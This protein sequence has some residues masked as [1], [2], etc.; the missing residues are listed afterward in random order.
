LIYRL[1]HRRLADYE[2]RIQDAFDHCIF[3]SQREL[4]VFKQMPSDSSKI[5]VVP[6][7]VDFEY[8]A[9]PQRAVKPSNLTA[10][11]HP[12]LVFTGFMDYFANEDG[13]KWFCEKIF[14]GI[15]KEFPTAEFYIVGNQPSNTVRGLS[16]IDGVTV[17]GYVEDIREFYWMAD[18]CVIPLRIARG[19]QNKVLESMAAGNAV[20][21]TS[22]ASDGIVC[23]NTVDIVIA[24]DAQ[25]FA[26]RVIELLRNED[27]RKE[28]GRKAAQNIR[29]RYSWEDNL[30]T[31]DELLK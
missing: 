4:D 14:P 6:N 19:M 30:K 13:A 16:A 27:L 11:P 1:E 24:D 23:S 17:T 15:R 10:R 2:V 3:V 25:T 12:L 20:I 7:G 21:A 22:N 26:D 18:I 5:H 29:S 9:R 8:F 28:L 31:F